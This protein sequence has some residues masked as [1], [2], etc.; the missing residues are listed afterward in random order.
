MAKRII[1]IL[2]CPVLLT[3]CFKSRESK[4][5]ETAEK[6]VKSYAD[7]EKKVPSAKNEQAKVFLITQTETTLSSNEEDLSYPWYDTPYAGRWILE[8]YKDDLLM[9]ASSDSLE[10][11]FEYIQHTDRCGKNLKYIEFEG[12]VVEEKFY[13]KNLACRSVLI[14]TTSL[15]ITR[16][17]AFVLKDTVRNLS[18]Q[19]K[20]PGYNELFIDGEK[21]IKGLDEKEL[22]KGLDGVYWA[23]DSTMQVIDTVKFTRGNFSQSHF[24]AS[25]TFQAIEDLLADE[26]PKLTDADYVVMETYTGDTVAFQAIGGTENVPERQAETFEMV[27]TP[28]GFELY[29]HTPHSALE[30]RLLFKFNTA[31]TYGE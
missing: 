25:M 8:A 6:R 22:M 27:R 1:L 12:S 31:F 19:F 26:P 20:G 2:L 13:L 21:Y 30:P 14:G 24:F 16:E 18:Y 9:I 5:A 7:K 15:D 10:S 3:N 23:Y 28:Y 4:Q 29:E 11:L 17:K